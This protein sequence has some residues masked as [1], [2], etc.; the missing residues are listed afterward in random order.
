MV[1]SSA[2]MAFAGKGVVDVRFT[3]PGRFSSAFGCW[4]SLSSPWPR[5]W[6]LNEWG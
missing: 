3:T 6:Y 2:A 5:T 4:G 1:A